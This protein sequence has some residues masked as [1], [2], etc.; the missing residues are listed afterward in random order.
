MEAQSLVTMETVQ[1]EHLTCDVTLKNF[2]SKLDGS[3]QIGKCCLPKFD[4]EGHLIKMH[5]DFLRSLD[6]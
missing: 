2:E 6:F 4:F 3:E 5:N 1:N